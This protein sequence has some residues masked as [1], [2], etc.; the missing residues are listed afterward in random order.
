MAP[1]S[2]V[3][4]LCFAAAAALVLLDQWSKAAVFAWL[5]GGSVDLV[6]D[7]HGHARLPLVGDWLSFMLS[8]NRGAAFGRFG[9]WPHLLVAG[10]AL[11]VACLTW[12][13]AT[14]DLRQ[15][16][17]TV[18]IVLVLAGAVGNLLDNLFFGGVESDH[19]YG[20]VRDFIDV[21]F[22]GWD[23][24]FPTFNVADSCITVGAVLWVASGFFSTSKEDRRQPGDVAG[25][26]DPT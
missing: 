6:R 13:L 26:E 7:P 23:W 12:L 20:T 4:L 3:R 5:G 2:R 1:R 8:T 18:A 10:R 17:V 24:H 9:E 15:R 14:I 16:A 22:T 25:A 19:P 11:A 21:W